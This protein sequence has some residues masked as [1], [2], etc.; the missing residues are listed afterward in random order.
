MPLQ[1]QECFSCK[2]PVGM[3][4]QNGMAKKPVDWKSYLLCILAWAA[5]VYYIWHVFFKAPS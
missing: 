5:F 2:K 1:A 3:V 4:N